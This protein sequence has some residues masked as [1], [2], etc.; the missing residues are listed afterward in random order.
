LILG[1][2]PCLGFCGPILA[3]FI[4]A[5][6]PSFKKGLFAY[7]SFSAGKLA[8]YM[9]IGALCGLFSGILKNA[10]FTGGLE[11][12]NA[13][14]GVLILG[15][16][17]LT[18]AFPEPLKNRFCSFFAR[19]NLRNA[20]LLGLL[21]GFAPCLPLLGILSYI[22]IIAHSVGEGVLYALAFGAGTAV[23]PVILLAGLSGHLAGGFASR[24]KARAVIRVVS[25]LLLAGMG[26]AILLK[27]WAASGV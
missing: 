25:G 9:F 5:Y 27:L 21:T 16:G 17:V 19:G 10:L 13:V 24:P 11:A 6:K 1:S 15:I 2:G 18:L 3:G 20:G 26:A 22:I 12:M 7:F 23:S 8:S 4:A 14:L